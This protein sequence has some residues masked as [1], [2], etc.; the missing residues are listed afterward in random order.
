MTLSSFNFLI[1]FVLVFIIYYFALKEKKR[2]QNWL[3]LLAS[4]VFYGLADYKMIVLLFTATTIFYYLG[5]LIKSSSQKKS[6][7][8][9][10]LGVVLS[11]GVL[12][13]FKYFNFFIH[14]FSTLFNNLGFNIN[15]ITLNILIPVGV[16][17][18]TFK[19]ISYI[20]ETYCPFF[21]TK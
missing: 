8:F 1:F 20:I 21:K 9:S 6:A 15:V 17:F 3:L 5:N 10:A 19:L 2:L 13:Y 14:S 12:F 7:I 16:I 18:F 11:I 4:Y